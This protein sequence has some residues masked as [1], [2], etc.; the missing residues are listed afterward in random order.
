MV[1][2]ADLVKQAINGGYIG[3]PYAN[4]D[5]QGLVER[6]LRDAGF[7]Y[8][9]RGSNHMWR[10]A[11]SERHEEKPDPDKVPAGAWVFTLK[12]DGTEVRRGYH[13]N[14]GAAKHVGLYLGHNTVIHSTSSGSACVCYDDLTSSRWTA[15]GLCKYVDYSAECPAEP[16]TDINRALEAL[17]ILKQFIEG[18]TE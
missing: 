16:V 12:H 9:W 4:I 18:R 5:C 7:S 11:L 13:D 17:E 6:I 2:A 10:E 15:W 1:K 3:L 8:N 14:L